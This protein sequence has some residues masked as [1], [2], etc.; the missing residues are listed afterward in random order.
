MA[1][2]D[3]RQ[4]MKNNKITQWQIAHILGVCEQTIL[5]WFR[6]PL[7]GDQRQRVLSAINQLKKEAA[8]ND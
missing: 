5:R 4:E 3:I 1:N 6:F 8:K 2:E 7:E